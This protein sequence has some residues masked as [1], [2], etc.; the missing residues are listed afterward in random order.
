M[1]SASAVGFADVARAIGLAT[2][3]GSITTY[4]P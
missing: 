1:V 4:D 3:E 2:G